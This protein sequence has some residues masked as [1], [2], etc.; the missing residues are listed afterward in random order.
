M[1]GWLKAVFSVERKMEVNALSEQAPN[2]LSFDEWARIERG[3]ATEAEILTARMPEP[4]QVPTQAPTGLMALSEEDRKP[5]MDELRAK[6]EAWQKTTEAPT[7]APVNTQSQTMRSSKKGLG[8]Y[9]IRYIDDSGYETKR[10]IRVLSTDGYYLYSWCYLKN[11]RR[12]FFVHM[13]QEAVNLDTGEVVE[14]ILADI[15]SFHGLSHERKHEIGMNTELH[16]IRILFFVAKADGRLIKA[17]RGL[18][19]DYILSSESGYDLDAD[20]LDDMVKYI[21]E[22]G[23]SEFAR[24][25][26]DMAKK[27]RF[28]LERIFAYAKGI[29]ATEKK[30]NPMEEAA[31]KIIENALT[32]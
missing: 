10:K 18:I 21:D 28:K 2:S 27:D 32:V 12:T 19:A 1:F 23:V 29:V 7:Q 26:G 9:L 8:D 30:V 24:L 16:A 14:S 11:G 3:E 17:E 13:V 15:E 25:V 20:T 5:R 6:R 31:L 22:P 4:T